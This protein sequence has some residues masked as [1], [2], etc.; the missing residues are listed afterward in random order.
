LAILELKEN[1]VGLVTLA[2]QSTISPLLYK[3]NFPP[4][5][6]IALSEPNNRNIDM[7]TKPITIRIKV[8]ILY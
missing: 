7:S 4:N 2:S 6:T 8:I 3:I 5:V 1:V